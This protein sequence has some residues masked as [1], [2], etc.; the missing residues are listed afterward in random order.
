M[1]DPDFLLGRR[2]EF[3]D[4]SAQDMTIV[5]VDPEKGA[6]CHSMDG[7]RAWIPLVEITT[8]INMGILI[9]SAK[10]GF[11]LEPERQRWPNARWALNRS[12]TNTIRARNRKGDTV[13]VKVLS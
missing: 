7:T 8:A 12:A 6:R 5:G 13:V 11:V 4:K 1:I 3:A 2:Y 10:V 9:E